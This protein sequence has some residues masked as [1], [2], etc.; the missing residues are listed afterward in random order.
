MNLR[1]LESGCYTLPEPIPNPR[2]DKRKNDWHA[3]QTLLA[4]RYVVVTYE[5]EL[6]YTA[7]PVT[8]RDIHVRPAREPSYSHVGATVRFTTVEVD[9]NVKI[10]ESDPSGHATAL[11]EHFVRDD[12]LEG[13]LVY[14]NQ[15]RHV[16]GQDVLLQLVA[17]GVLAEDTVRVTIAAVR[18]AM[19]AEWEAEELQRELE[20]EKAKN[21]RKAS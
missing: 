5:Q 15:E 4:G 1:D 3:K 7:V 8:L 19:E 12:S 17:A 9:D 10:E 18:R 16:S 6:D 20:L 11:A 21:P 2:P 14:A 13:A